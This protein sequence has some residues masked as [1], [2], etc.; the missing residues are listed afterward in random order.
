[1][2]EQREEIRELEERIREQ[3]AVLQ[4]LRDVGESVRRERVEAGGMET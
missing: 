4:R 3:R 1:M 2:A